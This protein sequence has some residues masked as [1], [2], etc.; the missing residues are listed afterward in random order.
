[1]PT[2]IALNDVEEAI[3]KS[4]YP[5]Q[6]HISAQLSQSFDYCVEEWAFVDSDSGQQRAIDLYCLKELYDPKSLGDPQVRPQLDVL[7][8][9]KKSELPYIFF[10]SKVG[11]LQ[12]GYPLI[13]G[14]RSDEIT[15]KLKGDLSTYSMSILSGLGMIEHPFVAAAPVRCR[16]LSKLIANGKK[17]SLS[18]DEP[19]MSAVL[20]MTKAMNYL[21]EI[22]K[23][24]QMAMHFDLHLIF[25]IVVL[26]APMLVV[27]T[28]SPDAPL[29][30][31]P[32]VRLYRNTAKIG[33]RATS[34][35]KT[36][37]IDFVHRDYVQDFLAL[38]ITPF[39]EDFSNRALKRNVA[40]S[41]CKA[42]VSGVKEFPW[43]DVVNYY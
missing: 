41:K 2:H 16:T 15:F 13:S 32:W 33:D 18:G 25:G 40:L 19:F 35:S 26:D 31:A 11:G 22:S 37:A 21:A 36:L 24:S 12:G 34:I 1:L 17:L 28:S 4:G 8:E 29:E 9:C 30:F 10:R 23:P 5:L 6:T 7:I 39:T 3:R 38:H 42:S 20:P 14:L 27:D 43:M